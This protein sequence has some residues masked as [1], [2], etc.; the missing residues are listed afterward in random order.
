MLSTFHACGVSHK[1]SQVIL[2][3][4]STFCLCISQSTDWYTGQS[5][6]AI[7]VA[8]KCFLITSVVKCS[9]ANWICFILHVN[10]LFQ[11]LC[12]SQCDILVSY[13][14]LSCL[15]T[16]KVCCSSRVGWYW[17]ISCISAIMLSLT[18]WIITNVISDSLFLLYF[19]VIP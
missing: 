3:C 14:Q 9:A 10:W 5:F 4:Y 1:W 15:D 2:C 13:Y 19:G 8:T 11:L 18:F 12:S 7:T 17:Y 16:T 6:N